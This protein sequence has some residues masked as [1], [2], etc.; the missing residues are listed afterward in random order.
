MTT[1]PIKTYQPDQDI[2]WS[3]GV[4]RL[5]AVRLLASR[6][7]IWRL[8]VRDFTARYKQSL[9]GVGWAVLLPVCAIG[10]FVL[11]NA[12]GVLAV[13][14]IEAPYPAWALLNL[15]VWQVFAAGITATTGSIVAGGS[16]VV[17]INFPKVSLVIASLGN[18]IVETVIR[19]M[20]V[21]GVFIWFDITPSIT[22]FLAPLV[23]IPVLALTLGLGLFLSLMNA[24]LRDVI[25]VVTVGVTFL[26][27]ITPV[28]YADPGRGV[29]S[30]ISRFNPMA[31][32]IC[33]ARDLVLVGSLSEPISFAWSSAVSFAI[34][35]IAWRLFTMVEPRMVERV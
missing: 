7:L 32:F 18:V 19:I 5:M 6:E 1:E 10:T 23:L 24:L 26:L 15:T 35:F 9:L 25:H 13:G 28:L 20:M 14:D 11:L 27:L 21:V 34:L 22:T 29:L 30:A 12:S 3:A 4:W 16:M 17:K 33:A 31:V 8:F 2:G